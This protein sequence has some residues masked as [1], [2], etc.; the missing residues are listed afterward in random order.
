MITLGDLYLLVGKVLF[1]REQWLKAFDLLY[2][3]W[4]SDFVCHISGPIYFYHFWNILRA[5]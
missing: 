1:E 2:Y 5:T 3:S 4:M